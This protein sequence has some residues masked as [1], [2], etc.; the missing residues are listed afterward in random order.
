[1]DEFVIDFQ[2]FQ[3]P[4]K[5]VI[6]KELALSNVYTNV[7]LSWIV[8]S[9]KKFS[10]T[11]KTVEAQTSFFRQIDYV[12]KN[13]HGINYDDGCVSFYKCRNAVQEICKNATCVFVKGSERVKFVK[14]VIFCSN[15]MSVID[16]DECGCPTYCTKNSK[17]TKINHLALIRHTLMNIEQSC[18]S[19]IVR[20]NK[21]GHSK[22][23]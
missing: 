17:I 5:E 12:Q 11:F 4:N 3:G 14:E 18:R 16:L 19:I 7:N 9:P 10:F 15:S 21:H 20:A 6:I 13:I 22:Y 2:Y 23:G 8:R 1:M